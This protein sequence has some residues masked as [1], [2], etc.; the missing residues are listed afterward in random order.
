MGDEREHQSW[1]AHTATAAQQYAHT[2]SWHRIPTLFMVTRAEVIAAHEK[3]HT[4]ERE[5]MGETKAEA[6]L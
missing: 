1:F 3:A 6:Q 5:A 2:S 4:K